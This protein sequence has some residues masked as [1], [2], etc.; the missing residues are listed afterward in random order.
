LLFLAIAAGLFSFIDQ[1]L[2][3]TANYFFLPIDNAKSATDD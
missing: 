3:D 2:Y 1:G